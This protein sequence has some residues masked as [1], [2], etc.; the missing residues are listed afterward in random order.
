MS[1]DYVP[2]PTDWV[3]TQVEAI[4]ASGTT[5]AASIQGRQVVLLTMTGARTGATRKV[6]LMRVEHDGVYAAVGSRGGAPTD[7]QWAR[8]LDAE[9]HLTLLDGTLSSDR[10]ARRISGDEYA[11]WW[12]R[13]VDAFPP[14]ADYV[15]TASAAGRTIPLFLLEEE[16]GDTA[17]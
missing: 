6:P 11:T 14:Y 7:P 2:S 13:A 1:N 15:R 10:V 4:E 8:N 12:S 5:E 17:P 3:R 16:P 9:P